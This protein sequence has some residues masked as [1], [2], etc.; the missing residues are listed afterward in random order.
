MNSFRVEAIDKINENKLH[1]IEK[2]Y[3]CTVCTLSGAA[4]LM[5]KKLID[6][7]G[8]PSLHQFRLTFNWKN[9]ESF[10]LVFFSNF[11]SHEPD[12]RWK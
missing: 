10:S 8:Y 4:C 3:L 11:Q 12:E 5:L 1:T 9:T 2:R 7:L 6:S